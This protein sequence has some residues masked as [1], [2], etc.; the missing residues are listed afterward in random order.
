M[1][2][3]YQG[4]ILPSYLPS[5]Q[6]FHDRKKIKSGWR[7]AGLAPFDPEYVISKLDAK[8]QTPSPPGSSD[9]LELPWLPKTPSNPTEAL[10][11]TEYIEKRI[12]THQG[13]SSAEIIESLN[14]MAKSTTKVMQQMALLEEEVR[15]LREANNR[16]SRWNAS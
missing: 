10:S 15:T 5:T 6:S 1:S 7:G 2:P 16:L 11:Q 9:G 13:G 3:R 12:R 14:Q 4:R 8:L